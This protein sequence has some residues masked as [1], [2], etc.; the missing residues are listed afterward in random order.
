MKG[1]NKHKT[2]KASLTN[3]R[4]T[5]AQKKRDEFTNVKNSIGLGNA[6]VDFK[7]KRFQNISCK[8]DDRR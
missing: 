7:L 2:P 1:Y 6:S 8:V 4:Y 5:N 3:I